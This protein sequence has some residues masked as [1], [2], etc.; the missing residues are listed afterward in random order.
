PLSSLTAPQVA[1]RAG[2]VAPQALEILRT[3]SVPDAPAAEAPNGASVREFEDY[4]DAVEFYQR[5][6]WTDGLP[7]V[8]PTPELVAAVLAAGR[9]S[10]NETIGFNRV[11]RRTLTA[12]K[13]AVNAVMAGCLPEYA[14]VVFAV[15][16]AMLEDAF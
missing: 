16:A 2:E 10:P 9:R 1:A 13:V 11:R 12:E 4:A 8:L 14:P 7:I 5:Q 3:A 15:A 6:G